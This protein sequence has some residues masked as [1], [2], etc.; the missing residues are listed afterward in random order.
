[1][2]ASILY[3]VG[4]V[5]IG[6]MIGFAAPSITNVLKENILA[7]TTIK[8]LSTTG[9]T[10]WFSIN[11][12]MSSFL[13]LEHYTINNKQNIDGYFYFETDDGRVYAYKTYAFM[14]AVRNPA[15]NAA[16]TFPRPLVRGRISLSAGTSIVGYYV[17]V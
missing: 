12:A 7:N 14:N 2:L 17:S 8:G 11:G 4:V 13:T 6:R 9:D 3:I 1:M 15:L 10:G 16:L 5:T